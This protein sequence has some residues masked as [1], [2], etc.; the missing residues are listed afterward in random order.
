MKPPVKPV[1][2]PK[3]VQPRPKAKVVAQTFTTAP[4]KKVQAKTG[5]IKPVYPAYLRN[6]APSY[7]KSAKRRRLEGVVELKVQVSADGSVLSL[8]IF[9][10]CGHNALD[11]SALQTVRNW[12]FLPAKRNGKA[13][14]SD[15]IVPIRFQLRT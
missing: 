4:V 13:V 6:P 9:K 7:P 15:V 14:N 1:T 2:P 10:S 3:T 11:R 5:F 8:S 12:R